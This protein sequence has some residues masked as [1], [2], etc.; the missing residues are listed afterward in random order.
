MTSQTQQ[1]HALL[2][3]SV[4]FV[5]WVGCSSS[6]KDKGSGTDEGDG[7]ASSDTH[8]DTG[9]SGDGSGSGDSD[10]NGGTSD[11]TEVCDGI[12]NDGDGQI[13]NVDV[14]KDGLCDCLN[15]GTIGRI[16]PWST[17]GNI[18]KAWLDSRSP[19]PATELGD[20]VITPA[21]IAGLDVIV[22]LRADTA[23][24][25]VQENSPGHHEF[26]AGEI[27]ALQDWVRSGGGLMT[28]IGYQ[29]DEAAEVQNVN[30]LLAPLGVRYQSEAQYLG[31]TGYITSWGAHPI[32]EGV[33]TVFTDNG[34]EPAVDGASAIAWDGTGKV[35]MVVATPGDGHVIVFGD[36][37]ITY[38]SEWVNIAEQQV[39]RL[40][41]NMMKWMSPP[42]ECQVDPP[43]Q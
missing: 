31:L 1:R 11:S 5:A 24:L 9:T 16:G 30:R 12:D 21:L 25:P 23:A 3:I 18:F 41:L 20:Q 38:D 26:G 39:E 22:V 8:G 33:T 2:L 40:W 28:T 4:M 42:E 10:S 36:E 34:V 32:A 15:I 43:V 19:I 7:S 37:W 13:D 35:A 14:G 29:S 27:A 6:G 17:G